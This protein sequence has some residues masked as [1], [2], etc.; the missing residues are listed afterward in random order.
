MTIQNVVTTQLLT[1][2]PPPEKKGYGVAMI[3]T[4]HSKYVDR[5]RTYS[6]AD[7][8]LDDGWTVNDLVYEQATALL[9]GGGVD[10][11]MVG[12]R[13]NVPLQSV[14]LTPT[15]TVVGTVYSITIKAPGFASAETASYTVVALDTVATICDGLKIAIDLLTAGNGLSSAN[16]LCT[17]GTTHLDLTPVAVTGKVFR[18]SAPNDA[19]TFED[20]TADPGIVADI[21]AIRATPGGDAWWALY[22]ESNSKAEIVAAAGTIEGL[23]KALFY[24]SMDTNMKSTAYAPGGTGI[25]ATLKGL[26]YNRT[27]GCYCSDQTKHAYLRVMSLG[28]PKDPGTESWKYLRPVG[29][30]AEVLS[31]NEVTNLLSNNVNF[32][33][34]R[35]DVTFAMPGVAASGEWIDTV[36]GNDWFINSLEVDVLTMFLNATSTLGKISF[37]AN[38][39]ALVKKTVL[40][41]CSSAKATD[42]NPARLLAS[43]TVT[44]PDISQVTAADKAARILRYVVIEGVYAGAIHEAGFKVIFTT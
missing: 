40:A 44:T 42:A 11:F 12:K 2:G 32:I 39:I 15:S 20:R 29:V 7:D 30:S 5:H 33:V 36:R 21:A 14:R 34:D 24:T 43:Y 41:T 27:I 8:L 38:G 25:A 17:D 28:L 10:S 31:T 4:T 16:L 19:L 18:Y 37:T 22:C 6:Q 9:S 23:E 1:Q 3:L 13:N 35:A 26:S